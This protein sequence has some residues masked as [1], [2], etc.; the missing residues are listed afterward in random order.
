MPKTPE[1]LINLPPSELKSLSREEH[2]VYCGL[3]FEA[4]EKSNKELGARISKL[5]RHLWYFFIIAVLLM[6]IVAA[7]SV[8]VATY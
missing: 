4:L 2:R 1:D 5:D 6:L 8:A 7:T 3:K